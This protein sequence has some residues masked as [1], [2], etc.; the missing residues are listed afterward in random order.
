MAAHHWTVGRWRAAL[1]AIN[2]AILA[3]A[4]TRRSVVARRPIVSGAVARDNKSTFAARR[5]DGLDASGTS[6]KNQGDEGD[7]RLFH[8]CLYRAT[9]RDR[10]AVPAPSFPVQFKDVG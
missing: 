7:N 5:G 6:G 10:C 8:S 4:R 9:G 1:V 2:D 3:A